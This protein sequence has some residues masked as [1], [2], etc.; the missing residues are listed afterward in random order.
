MAGGYVGNVLCYENKR[1]L[2]IPPQHTKWL[3]LPPYYIIIIARTREKIARKIAIQYCS[4]IAIL[5]SMQKD[6][7]TENSMTLEAIFK[8]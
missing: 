7:M 8:A 3:P 5:M 4:D 2:L 6:N 1:Q